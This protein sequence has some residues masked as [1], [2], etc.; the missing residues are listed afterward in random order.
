MKLS[1]MEWMKRSMMGSVSTERV[2]CLYKNPKDMS[3]RCLGQERL[4]LVWY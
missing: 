4:R 3:L 2:G 1:Q